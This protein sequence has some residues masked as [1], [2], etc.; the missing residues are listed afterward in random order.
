MPQLDYTAARAWIN[1]WDRQQE[2]YLPDREDRFT[3]LIDT[4]EVATERPDPLLLDLGCGP[5]SLAERLLD[6]LP[7]ASVVAVDADPLL[8]ALGQAA[9][10]GHAGLRFVD[11]DLRN[12]GWSSALGL[13]QPA[14]A[15]VST[16]ALHW[17]TEEQLRSVYA[18]V[19][20]VLRPGGLLLNGDHFVLDEPWLARLERGLLGAQHR[21][22]A[23]D[24]AGAQPDGM[25]GGAHGRSAA[26]HGAGNGRGE[27]W[28]Q[29]WAAVA[30]DPAMSELTAERARRWAAAERHGTAGGRLD[31]HVEALEAA[32]FRQI[33]TLWQYGENRL[34]CA[35]RP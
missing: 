11:R 18:E 27:N 6:R 17:L 31:A 25:S 21:R 15:A 20:S 12:P 33:G 5:G 23:G 9:H 34:L 8:L 28:S 10:G 32:G 26:E 24:G 22:V 3:A 19:A 16:T 29:W 7:G 2:C 35:L 1:R 14:D 30:A 13:D 4:V